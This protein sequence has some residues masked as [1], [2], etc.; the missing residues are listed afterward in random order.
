MCLSTMITILAPPGSSSQMWSH[1]KSKATALNHLG[2]RDGNVTLS[3]SSNYTS[4]Y[5]PN[6]GRLLLSSLKK[7][8]GVSDVE[9]MTIYPC[10]HWPPNV[11]PQCFLNRVQ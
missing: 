10:C 11:S 5:V 9:Y 3:D 1:T 7:T 2:A 4:N 8:L 6:Y